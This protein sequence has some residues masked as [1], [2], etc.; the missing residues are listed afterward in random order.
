MKIISALI[1]EGYSRDST[2][3]NYISI[4]NTPRISKA[5]VKV[6]IEEKD[7]T[8]IINVCLKLVLRL[9][10]ME[11]DDMTCIGC[12]LAADGIC[13]PLMTIMN[14]CSSDD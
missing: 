6:L 4:S 13:K 12:N 2:E 5:I 9:V 11:F 14:I 8:D 1:D 7:D 10:T 3:A